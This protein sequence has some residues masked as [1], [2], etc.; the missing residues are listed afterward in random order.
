MIRKRLLIVVRECTYTATLIVTRGYSRMMISKDF[1]G[2]V[3]CRIHRTMGYCLDYLV[4]VK[5]LTRLRYLN[6][7]RDFSGIL[8]SGIT[9]VRSRVKLLP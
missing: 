3:Q 7:I 4:G 5:G 1:Q 8:D 6:Q 2:L 9:S